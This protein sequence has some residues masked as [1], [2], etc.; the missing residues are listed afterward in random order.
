MAQPELT[1]AEH[2]EYSKTG[3]LPESFKKR[4]AEWEGSQQ[5]GE[6]GSAET[7]SEEAPESSEEEEPEEEQ[8]VEEEQ[9][10]KS[11]EA[12]EYPVHKG[13]GYYEL[14]N[15]EKVQGKKA[16]QKAEQALT[17]EE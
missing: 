14:S 1:L 16:A 12:E 8:A 13:G 3:K 9:E 15:G 4:R 10:P 2:V 6:E 5:S 17:D 7:E 11:E